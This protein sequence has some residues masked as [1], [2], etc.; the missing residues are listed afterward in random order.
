ARRLEGEHR[1]RPRPLAEARVEQVVHGRGLGPA[2]AERL[3]LVGGLGLELR[4]QAR[5]R[6]RQ[7]HPGADDEPAGA[8]PEWER[9]ERLH[10]KRTV[11]PPLT[12]RWGDGYT[13][14]GAFT[15]TVRGAAAP[16][17]PRFT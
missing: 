7:Q 8:P 14:P 15:E 12:K 6:D 2:R 10:R 4:L 17:T 1:G 5:E 3:A 16:R 13:A 11:P 9:S